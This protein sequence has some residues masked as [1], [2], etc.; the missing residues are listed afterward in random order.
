MRIIA[1][2]RQIEKDIVISKSDSRFLIMR[3]FFICCIAG[4]FISCGG[5]DLP[6]PHSI[7]EKDSLVILVQ[8]LGTVSSD[9]QRELA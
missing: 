4:M 6:V 8:P 3:N 2:C 9:Y 1:N 5:G 7:N